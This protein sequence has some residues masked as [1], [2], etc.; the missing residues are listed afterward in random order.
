MFFTTSDHP[1]R[2]TE[3]P[4]SCKTIW[5]VL[6]CPSSTWTSRVTNQYR[7]STYV[8]ICRVSLESSLEC[9]LLQGVRSEAYLSRSWS[10]SPPNSDLLNVS[11]EVDTASVRWCWLQDHSSVSRTWKYRP[12]TSPSII[13]RS[14]LRVTNYIM[15][16]SKLSYTS[17]LHKA[18]LYFPITNILQALSRL[19]V[20]VLNP[21]TTSSR[22]VFD[23][24]TRET[25]EDLLDCHPLRSSALTNLSV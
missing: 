16:C 6:R 21:S 9:D 2:S 18:L 20:R 23:H 19:V 5:S 14:N 12:V 1:H 7:D 25:D 17:R 24:I 10:S 22:L 11:R 3:R 4:S 15:S 13:S 8:L